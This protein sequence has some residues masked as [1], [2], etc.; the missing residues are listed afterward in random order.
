VIAPDVLRRLPD[1]ARQKLLL[2]DGLFADAEAVLRQGGAWK[3]PGGAI[4]GE[5]R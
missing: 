1:L 2:M 5:R 3:T 4:P